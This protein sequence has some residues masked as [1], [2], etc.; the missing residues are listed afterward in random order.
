MS[1]SSVARVP[2]YL[3]GLLPA[4]AAALIAAGCAE[5]RAT[6]AASNPMTFS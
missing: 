5:P 1:G 2:T 4:A 6:G 3:Y